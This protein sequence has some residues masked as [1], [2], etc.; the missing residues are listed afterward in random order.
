[1]A[2]QAQL[3]S[4]SYLEIDNSNVLPEQLVG[5]HGVITPTLFGPTDKPYPI[6]TTTDFLATFGGA[7]TMRSPFYPQIKRALQRGATIYVQRLTPTATSGSAANAATIPVG[8][9]E[10]L[11]AAAN[12]TIEAK[13]V[14]AWANGKL[15]IEFVNGTSSGV[16]SLRVRYAP[17]TAIEELF[18]GSS[19]TDLFTKVNAWST[20]ITITV[21]G[22]AVAP[23]ST[24]A[25]VFMTTGTDGTFTDDAA[26][27]AAVN[28]LFQN[29]NDLVNL[30][31]ISA[32]G[33]YTLSHL[34]NLIEYC[35]TRGD[36][37]GLFEVDPAKTAAEAKTFMDT[38]AS[39][40]STYV[41][42]YY[43][44]EL[45]AYSAELQTDVAGPVLMDVIA[46]FSYSDTVGARY[47]APA[48]SKRGQ[49]PNVK[50]FATNMLS[51]ARKTAAD[52]LVSTACNI[53]GNHPSFGPVVWGAATFNKGASAA[54]P[55]GTVS[56]LD[57][58]HVRRMLIDLHRNL[59]PVFQASLFD[60]QDPQTWRDAYGKAKPYLS[61]LEKARAIY[62]GW[63]YIGDQ[64]ASNIQGARYNKPSDLAVGKYKVL[65]PMVPVG[66]ISQIN[67]TVQVNSLL[68]MFQTAVS[69]AE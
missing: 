58:I 34:E 69:E 24:S 12:F 9:S 22:T 32:L 39:V 8:V 53:V 62:P 56:A 2:T 16:W 50:S 67:F 45:T 21:S 44:S 35:E 36:V 23:T 4:V 18:T 64:G 3:P 6:N 10:W 5:A 20:L 63:Q 33:V 30:D 17:N 11:T 29:F 15:G 48:G 7:D 66:F 25:T 68:S 13:T 60:P 1:M 38:T 19:L 47:Q 59:M 46:A 55:S 52:G 43:G 27:I 14:G 65:I 26:K 28:T 31:T 40:N 61:R 42:V 37:F 54:G 49:I 57:A 51:P 41:A